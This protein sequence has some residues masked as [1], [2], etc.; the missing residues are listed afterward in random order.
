MC[1]LSDEEAGTLGC[2]IMAAAGDGA[3]ESIAD[4]IRKA[5]HIDKEFIPNPDM[6]GFYEEKFEKYKKLYELMY[7]F[8]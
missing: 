1:T 6:Y 4:G 2:M 3:Y 5:V 7:N 8:K